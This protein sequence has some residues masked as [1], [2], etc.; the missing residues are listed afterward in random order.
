MSLQD[1][2]LR[3]RL[4]QYFDNTEEV[5][6]GEDWLRD[7]VDRLVQELL[8]VELGKDQ[9]KLCNR[10]IHKSYLAARNP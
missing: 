9:K 7:M 6:E 10:L 3:Q 4:Q 5:K 8:D 2:T 1:D